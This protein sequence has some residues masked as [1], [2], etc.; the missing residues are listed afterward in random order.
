[1]AS[2]IG[3]QTLQHTNGTNG[4]TIDSN[5]NVT[6]TNDL[7]VTDNLFT[8]ARPVWRV[9]LTGESANFGSASAETCPFNTEHILQ[10]GVTH[11]AGVVTVPVAGIYQI[12]FFL[13]FDTISS[14]YIL[15]KGMINNQ[16]AG[17]TRSYIIEQNP[18]T[19]YHTLVGADIAEMNAGDTYRVKGYSSGDSSWHFNSTSKFSGYLVG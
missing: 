15:A 14:G 17:A 11:S 1:M 7:T 3:V 12:N 16:D 18:G 13:R 19:S 4:L 6:A 2:V 9:G 8:P 5:G 10:G